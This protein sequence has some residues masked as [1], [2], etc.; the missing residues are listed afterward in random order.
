MANTYHNYDDNGYSPY[1]V[2]STWCLFFV[3]LLAVYDLQSTF[4]RTRGM[5]STYPNDS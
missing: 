5:H 2:N 4:L 1:K 3:S